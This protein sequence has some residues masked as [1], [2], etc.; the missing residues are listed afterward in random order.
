MCLS[1]IARM[2]PVIIKKSKLRDQ[3][4][5]K[6]LLDRAQLLTLSAP[7]MTVILFGAVFTWYLVLTSDSHRPGCFDESNPEHYRIDS[8]W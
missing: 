5:T 3:H 8:L 6:Y 4:R 1:P 2:V 7:E